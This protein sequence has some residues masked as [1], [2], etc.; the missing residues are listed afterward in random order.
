MKPDASDVRSYEVKHVETSDGGT[1]Y[2][3]HEGTRIAEQLYTRM[4]PHRIDV[5]RT[6]AEPSMRGHGLARRLVDALVAWARTTKTEVSA[7]CS[8]TVSRFARDPSI[9]DVFVEKRV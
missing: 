8:Y 4:G 5:V 7:T 3:E 1:F 2:I 9:R 6:W